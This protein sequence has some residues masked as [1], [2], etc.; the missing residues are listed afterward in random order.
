[1]KILIGIIYG[2]TTCNHP[3]SSRDILIGAESEGA[4]PI[5]SAS[6]IP[7]VRLARFYNFHKQL[8]PHLVP[9][10]KEGWRVCGYLAK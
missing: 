1:V 7:A 4:R 6:K 9:Y 5:S 8:S 2:D 3:H 10:T